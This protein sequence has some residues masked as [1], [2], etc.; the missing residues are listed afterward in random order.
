MKKQ[1]DVAELTNEVADRLMEEAANIVTLER[2]VEAAKLKYRNT[3]FMLVD[4]ATRG[5]LSVSREF[6]PEPSKENGA[7]KLAAAALGKTK[8]KKPRKA[9][10]HMNGNGQGPVLNQPAEGARPG[11]KP[12]PDS[13]ASR[14]LSEMQKGVP[15][16]ADDLVKRT[17]L[18]LKKVQSAIGQL[19]HQEK[20]A[21]LSRGVYRLADE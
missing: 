20:L 15:S 11:R 19:R 6:P 3:V 16:T 21:T 12:S 9:A 5:E 17:G 8:V 18:T 1:I 14:V 2:A 7:T 10:K 13:A 4:E